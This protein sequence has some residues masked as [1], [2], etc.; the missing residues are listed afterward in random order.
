MQRAL[1]VES[2]RKILAEV[3]F[4]LQV[5]FLRVQDP[6]FLVVWDLQK[7]TVSVVDTWC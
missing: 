3:Q 1:T 2:L 7:F 4:L 6:I 5:R